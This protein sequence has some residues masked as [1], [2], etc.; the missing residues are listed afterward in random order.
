MILQSLI[1]KECFIAMQML[2]QEVIPKCKIEAI[3]RQFL[4]LQELS[5]I[6]KNVFTWF[7]QYI[8]KWI[9]SYDSCILS[10]GLTTGSHGKI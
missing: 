2:S 7:H 10:K 4:I 6:S 3:L 9:S 8:E 5:R 1:A